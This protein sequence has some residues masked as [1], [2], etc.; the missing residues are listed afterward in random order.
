M[1]E[2]VGDQ[3]MGAR[4][5][6]GSGPR[7]PRRPTRWS[8]VALG[9]VALGLLIVVQAASV[10]SLEAELTAA[11]AGVITRS[12]TYVAQGYG[13]FFWNV[14]TPE[15]HGLRITPEC[16]LAYVTGPFLIMGG[17]LLALGRLSPARVL[18]G[19]IVGLALMVILNTARILLI[20][21]AVHLWGTGSALWWSHV[22]LGSLVAL[23]GNAAAMA[24]AIR[25]AFANRPPVTG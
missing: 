16:S 24:V 15:V 21:T 20:V 4:P 5:A 12:E 7:G 19:L 1:T 6:P 10:R 11:L 18:V 13:A 8:L 14:G 9:L 2:H 22:V 25:L 3:S 23:L 17:V